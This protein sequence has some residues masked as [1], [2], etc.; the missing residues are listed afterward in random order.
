MLTEKSQW[1]ASSLSSL[2]QA[3]DAVTTQLNISWD[4][5]PGAALRFC[6]SHPQVATVLVGIQNE[7]ELESAMQAGD[8]GALE[9]EELAR[10]QELGL[11]DENLLNPSTWALP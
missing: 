7:A 11:T 1:L 3:V 9:P 8:L 2:R 5:L 4:S 6:L 10:A